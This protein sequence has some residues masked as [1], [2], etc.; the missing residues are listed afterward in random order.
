[1]PSAPDRDLSAPP[2]VA[3]GEFIEQHPGVIAGAVLG[4][5]VILVLADAYLWGFLFFLAGIAF[6]VF[7][8]RGGSLKRQQII[9]R[10]DALIDGGKGQSEAVVKDTV[11]G[12]VQREIP[13]IAC[14]QVALAPGVL[15]GMLGTKRPF[16]VVTH[17]HNARLKPFKM[18]VNVR[19]YGTTLQTSWYLAYQPK[20]WQRVRLVTGS[21][22]LDLFDEQDLR[23]YVTAT[24][25]SF[26]DAVITLMTELGKD[27]SNLNRTSKGF[28]GIS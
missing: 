27:T 4:L 7:L 9:D 26:L 10:W 16:L 20:L 23:A 8:S 1:M 24:H 15:K 6:L 21:L 13:H 11:A 14:Q 22:G 25:H 19:D 5:G 12:L 2:E 17:N 28:L 3:I 18:Y